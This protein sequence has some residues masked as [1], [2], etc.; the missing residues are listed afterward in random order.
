[1]HSVN[2][3]WYAVPVFITMAED[4]RPSGDRSGVRFRDMECAGILHDVDLTG[5]SHVGH[6]GHL[7]CSG[8]A[9]A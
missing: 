3:K 1:M 4:G 6:L 7:R 5:G 8:S 2:S 9:N